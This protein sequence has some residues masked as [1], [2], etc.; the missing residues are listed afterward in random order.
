[1]RGYCVTFLFCF[2]LQH[3]CQVKTLLQNLDPA[4]DD[5]AIIAQEDGCKVWLD[6]VM[7]NLAKLAGG[8]LKSFI[9]S[10]Q[11]FIQFV[12]NRRPRP[13][14]PTLTPEVQEVFQEVLARKKK[15]M[16]LFKK[17]K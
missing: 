13:G 16:N 6:W 7:P 11:M 4:G 15:A 17:E 8:T 14:F 5:I 2:S 12:V 9:N 1:M 10:L 3:A